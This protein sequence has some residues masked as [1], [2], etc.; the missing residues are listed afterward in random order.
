MF[1]D[2]FPAEWCEPCKK[3]GNYPDDTRNLIYTQSVLLPLP[4][5][6]E[7]VSHYFPSLIF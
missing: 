2:N 4:L 1:T 5:Q 3:Y 7:N 6:V